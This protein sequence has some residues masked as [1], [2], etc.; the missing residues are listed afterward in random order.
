MVVSI[1]SFI[2]SYEKSEAEIA[3][4]DSDWLMAASPHIF[5]HKISFGIFLPPYP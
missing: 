3:I 5:L 2:S 1:A 4:R